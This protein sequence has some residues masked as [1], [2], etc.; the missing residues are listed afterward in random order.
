[1]PRT[2]TT[3]L[4]NLL[5]CD[6]N[7]R[8]LMVWETMCPALSERDERRGYEGRRRRNIRFVIN[9][10][11]WMIPRLKQVH[12]FE[13]N[14]PEECGWLLNNSF[15]SLMFQLYGSIPNY[16][17]FVTHLPRERLLLAY[18]YYHQQLQLLQAGDTSR[19]WVLK[20]PVHQGCL[21]ELLETIP[22]ANVIQTHR[23][24]QKVVASACSLVAL[25]RGALSDDLD[26]H[27]LG[28]EVTQRLH[29]SILKAEDARG[30]YGH[31]MTDVLFDS[32]VKDQIGT[33]RR[34]YDEFGYEYTAEFESRMQ[35]WLA[36]NP[37]H[38]HGAHKYSLEQFGLTAQGIDS[39]FGDYWAKARQMKPATVTA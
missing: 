9:F 15:V 17:D 36:N 32:L 7:C 26:L 18:Q 23:D 22:S 38:K 30:Q 21:T 19:H 33:V 20:S 5:A 29:N 39:L 8:P 6:P 2:G 31:R 35:Q 28:Q 4:Y 25:T 10:T 12:S 1:M 3:L 24:P 37:E 16:F 11:N 27:Q 14:A 13:S 34:I